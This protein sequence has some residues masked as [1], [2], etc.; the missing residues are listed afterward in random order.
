MR[1][2]PRERERAQPLLEECKAKGLTPNAK[3]YI[4]LI[5]YNLR[6]GKKEEAERL[7]VEMAEMKHPVNEGLRARVA[8]GQV[9]VR[10]RARVSPWPWSAWYRS[11]ARTPRHRRRG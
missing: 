9:R 4:T 5:N 6:S 7:L 3:M 1:A 2:S 11:R 8:S 10:V